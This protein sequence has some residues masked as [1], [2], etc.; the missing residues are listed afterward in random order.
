MRGELLELVT[1]DID[2]LQSSLS[3]TISQLVTSILTMQAV[4]AMMVPI[5]PAGADHTADGSSLL[6]TRAI[7]PA[8]TVSP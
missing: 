5:R 2:N 1:N 4:L 6:V 8:V 7:T 3:M